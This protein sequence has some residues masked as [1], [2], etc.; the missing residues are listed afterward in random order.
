MDQRVAWGI[1]MLGA[2]DLLCVEAVVLSGSSEHTAGSF[3]ARVD[4]HLARVDEAFAR[5]ATGAALSAWQEAHVAA[6]GQPPVGEVDRCRRRRP[7]PSDT[8][9]PDLPGAG[10]RGIPRRTV[11][12]TVG[13]SGRRR[14]SDRRSLRGARRPTGCRAVSGADK[15]AAAD[16]SRAAA[17]A[18]GAAPR[19]RSFAGRAITASD[20]F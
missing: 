2:V 16:A 13:G 8:C 12:S 5:N 6:A 20:V 10:T 3:D 7:N 11:P 9:N 14:A 17:N 15:W 19:G 1:A 18:G 4:R